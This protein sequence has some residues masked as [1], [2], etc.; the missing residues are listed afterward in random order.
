FKRDICPRFRH[1]YISNS[2]LLNIDSISLL[3]ASLSNPPTVADRLS[4]ATNALQARDVDPFVARSLD[5]LLRHANLVSVRK[6]YLSIPCGS[7]G[8]RVGTLF[9]EDVVRSYRAMSPWMAPAMNVTREEF[10]NM[11]SAMENEQTPNRTYLNWYVAC[12]R[13]PRIIGTI[14]SMGIEEQDVMPEVEREEIGQPHAIDGEIGFRM[15][16]RME[17]RIRDV[18]E[19]ALWNERN[20]DIELRESP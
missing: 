4:T 10:E 15:D 16:G 5:T 9:K 6:N 17:E 14:G 18:E 19:A 13:K 8:G 20:E 2:T 7:W 3:F 12:G 1:G 11:L